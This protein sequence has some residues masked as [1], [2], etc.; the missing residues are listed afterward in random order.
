MEPKQYNEIMRLLNEGER[1]F[2]K[3][4]RM[5]EDISDQIKG[6]SAKDIE[7]IRPRQEKMQQ[8]LD[9]HRNMLFVPIFISKLP[10]WVWVGIGTV[11]I[12]G[13]ADVHNAGL[14]TL[15]KTIIKNIS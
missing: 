3:Q 12:N 10:K 2:D 7:G 13:Y 4:D 11:V 8:E 6:N 14:I 5:L 1:R 9:K 15:I